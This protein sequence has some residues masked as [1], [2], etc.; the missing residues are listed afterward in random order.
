MPETHSNR[1]LYPQSY[2]KTVRRKAKDT[3]TLLKSHRKGRLS[4]SYVARP[5]RPRV[6]QKEK[7]EFCAM[8]NQLIMIY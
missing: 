1:T 7:L 6:T 3:V 8:V 2:L 4:Y 5:V